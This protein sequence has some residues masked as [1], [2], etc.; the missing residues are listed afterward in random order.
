MVGTNGENAPWPWKAVTSVVD[1]FSKPTNTVKVLDFVPVVGPFARGVKASFDE[2]YSAEQNK[3][4]AMGYVDILA[5]AAIATGVGAPEGAAAIKLAEAGTDAV[6]VAAADAAVEV[7]GE[8]AANEVAT[9][10]ADSASEVV[11]ESAVE[12]DSAAV[13]QVPLFVG[14]KGSLAITAAQLAPDLADC[15]KLA[16]FVIKEP[17]KQLLLN[18]AKA[19]Q[20]AMEDKAKEQR[21]YDRELNAAEALAAEDRAQADSISEVF[22]KTGLWDY[23]P[24][25][26]VAPSPQ[27]HDEPVLA[28]DVVSTAYHPDLEPMPQPQSGPAPPSNVDMLRVPAALVLTGVVIYGAYSAYAG[29]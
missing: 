14:L 17:C 3:D 29:A 7:G 28:H 16:K 24:P 25:S 23:V 10:A 4:I 13:G 26:V 12:A 22:E 6:L 1:F 20:K 2:K 27:Q 18:E 19:K 9:I 5:G 11:L 15:H 8:V 21:E